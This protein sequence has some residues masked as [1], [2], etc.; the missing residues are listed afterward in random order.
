MMKGKR[1]VCGNISN[2][3]INWLKSQG[4]TQPSIEIDTYSIPMLSHKCYFYVRLE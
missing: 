2:E 4:F 3:I 1:I